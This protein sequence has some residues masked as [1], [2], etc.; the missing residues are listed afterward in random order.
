MILLL[1]TDLPLVD[2]ILFI[3]IE[4]REVREQEGKIMIS[5]ELRLANIL[6]LL[7]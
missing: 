1:P 6:G 2:N 5:F 3:M 4:G 7:V